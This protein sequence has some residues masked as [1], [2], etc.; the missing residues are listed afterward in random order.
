MIM[1]Q[2]TNVNQGNVRARLFSSSLY[3]SKQAWGHEHKRA[4]TQMIGVTP[5]FQTMGLQDSCDELYTPSLVPSSPIKKIDTF[6]AMSEDHTFRT[7]GLDSMPSQ[8]RGE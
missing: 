4:A 3:N 6:G 7:F 5:L 1:K 2:M 8:M